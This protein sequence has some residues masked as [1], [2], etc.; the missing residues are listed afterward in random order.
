MSRRSSCRGVRPKK[1]GGVGG[2]RGRFGGVEEAARSPERGRAPLP[3]QRTQTGPGEGV[4]VREDGSQ[5]SNG[6]DGSGIK[7]LCPPKILGPQNH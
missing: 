1:A 6:G 5:P 7:L 3:L 2:V 4:A